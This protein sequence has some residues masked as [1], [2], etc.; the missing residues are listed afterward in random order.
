MT[1]QDF[2][3][4]KFLRDGYL[5]GKEPNAFLKACYNNFKK[6]QR[7]LCLGEGEGRNAVYLAQKGYEVAAI[8]ASDVGL[9]KL[10]TFAKEQNVNVKTIC[11][12]LN[13]WIPK[14]KYG[15]IIFSYLHLTSLEQQP[16]FEKIEDSLKAK[17]FFI[18]EV[19]S[20]NQLNFSS[21]GPKDEDLLY[22]V[23]DFKDAF[24]HCIIHKLEEV[25]VELDEGKGH[26]GKAS[27]IRIIAQ[28]S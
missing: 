12:D 26:Q 25:E 4:E 15:A 14:K 10:E 19:F 27:V 23:N 28:R 13:E 22:S 17:G 6:S 7:V 8:D 20:K 1:Q 18:A 3:N 5:Y 16:L 2:W 21:G 9:Q 24:S 11:Q